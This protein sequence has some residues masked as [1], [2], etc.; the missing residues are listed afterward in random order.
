M[1]LY[2]TSTARTLIAD[3]EEYRQIRPT[4]GQHQ[5]WRDQKAL[6][7][8]MQGLLSALVCVRMD[9]PNSARLFGQQAVFSE[10][11]KRSCTWALARLS[12]PWSSK[13]LRY[14]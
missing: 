9:L 2:H 13:Y 10:P 8:Y 6:V 5:E 1:D 7:I 11:R 12:P 4:Q 3:L 14:K